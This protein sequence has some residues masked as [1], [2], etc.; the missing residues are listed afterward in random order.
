MTP[1]ALFRHPAEAVLSANIRTA[2]DRV[3]ASQWFVLG[4]EVN[5]FEQEFAQYC[6]ASHCVTVA[7]GTD[8]LELALR[9][10]GVSTGD[11]VM[12]AANG[13]FYSSTAIRL[14][15]AEPFYVEIDAGTMALSPRH[16]ES[17]LNLSPRAV[18]VTHLYGQLAEIEPIVELARSAGIPV[19]EDCA[20]SHGASRQGRRAGSFGTVG[21]YS[22]YPTKNLGALGDG[23]AVVSNDPDVAD[24][25]RTLRQYGWRGKYHNV[26]PGGRNSRLDELQAAVLR[27]KLPYLDEWNA[28]RRSIA[29]RYNR[30][31]RDLPVG[32]PAS[33]GEDFVAHLYTLRLKARSAFREFLKSNRIATD[34]HYPIPDHL[35]E[36]YACPQRKGA[37]PVTE[38]ACETVVSLPCFPGLADAEVGYVIDRVRQFFAEQANP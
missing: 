20:Q 5:A 18:I 4:T 16:F 13:G 24:K 19:V 10:V 3:L 14:I 26:T 29:V 31:F 22:F 35:Q 21:C 28:A 15:G 6:G 32:V 27:A 17:A 12:C 38:D 34:I 1:V 25:V 23:G 11:C 36:A 33:I 8:A 30:A 37:L 2:L 9:G 7:N